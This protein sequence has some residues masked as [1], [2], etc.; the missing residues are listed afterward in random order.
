MELDG[1]LVYGG[2]DPTVTAGALGNVVVYDDGTVRVIGTTPV[3]DDHNAPAVLC[4]S[5]KPPIAAWTRHGA[6]DKVYVRKGTVNADWT[7]LGSESTLDIG[8]A[9]SYTSLRRLPD[10]DELILFSR[11]DL[12]RW[13]FWTS[14]N[15]GSSWSGPTTLFDFGVGAHTY[16]RTAQSGNV[17]NCVAHDHWEVGLDHH[18]M[19]FFTI[20]LDS[21]AIATAS[22]TSLG[23]LD[24]TGLPLDLTDLAPAAAWT[25]TAGETANSCNVAPTNELQFALEWWPIGGDSSDGSIL[26]MRWDGAAWD[27]RDL[28]VAGD[29]E[30]GPDPDIA[31]VIVEQG[32]EHRTVERWTTT[33]AWVTWSAKQIDQ[34]RNVVLT[35]LCVPIGRDEG[36]AVV[37]NRRSTY[38]NY[39]AFVSSLA[40]P[41][42]GY[43]L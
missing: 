23:N 33:D 43:P 8:T 35:R 16:L 38:L 34:S 37:W 19:Y 10:T 4:Y 9:A 6:T 32:G 13:K 18:T 42:T 26:I 21:G 27:E 1:R 12:V 22:G 11:D 28:G 17:L 3:A 2:I 5:D 24:G 39:D 31:Y 20:N 7:S 41:P 36:P 15:Y 30:F 25:P 14:T 29:C 40:G